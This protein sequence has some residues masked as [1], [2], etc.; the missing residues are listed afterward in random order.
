MLCYSILPRSTQESEKRKKNVGECNFL[1]SLITSHVLYN[2]T[3]LRNFYF[4]YNYN[5]AALLFLEIRFC[6]AR[7]KKFFVQLV[8]AM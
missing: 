3:R 4:R 6:F 8:R 7:K 2:K 5:I 1:N